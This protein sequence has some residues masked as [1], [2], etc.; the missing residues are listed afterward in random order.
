[1]IKFDEAGEVVA[2]INVFNIVNVVITVSSF[3]VLALGSSFKDFGCGR[4]LP[5][6]PSDLSRKI[7]L[8]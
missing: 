5:G 8:L 3:C 7:M 4:C 1:M 2:P 6:G